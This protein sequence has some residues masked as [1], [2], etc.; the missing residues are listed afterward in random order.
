[1][2]IGDSCNKF[3]AAMNTHPER[4]LMVW[5]QFSASRHLGIV[6]A[7]LVPA[8]PITLA[9]CSMLG[10]AGTCPATTGRSMIQNDQKPL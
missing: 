2:V 3:A 10:V 8:I 5:N 9:L 7:G 6:M 4:F 1:M